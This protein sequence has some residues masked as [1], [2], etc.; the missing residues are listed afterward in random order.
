MLKKKESL[1][2]FFLFLLLF[3][4]YAILNNALIFIL[5][6][7]FTN[8]DV[9]NIFTYNY[10]GNLVGCLVHAQLIKLNQIHN[11]SII[12]GI[13]LV[14]FLISLSCWSML[15]I[16]LFKITTYLKW[17][18]I[19]FFSLFL[20]T[21]LQFISFIIFNYNNLDLYYFKENYVI[22]ILSII[23]VV[24]AIHLF[25]KRF[26]KKE[27]IQMLI[28]VVPGSFISAILWLEYLG[29]VLMPI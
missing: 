23:I 12:N 29:P 9:S 5:D 18:L 4:T 22:T 25:L 19:F 6:L 11:F 15:V 17:I 8:G 26:N 2:I 21:S 1:F 24:L 13:I 14:S 20:Y 16:K 28:F 27:K 10:T 3:P 7:L